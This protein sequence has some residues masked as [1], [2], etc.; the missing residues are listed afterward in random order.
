MKK[1]INE[2]AFHYNDKSNDELTS[3]Y[4]LNFN[5]TFLI[6]EIRQK[7]GKLIN[8]SVELSKNVEKSIRVI[9]DGIMEPVSSNII[10]RVKTFQLSLVSQ[11]YLSVYRE[12]ISFVDGY[13]EKLK[14]IL[15]REAQICK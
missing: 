15:K 8:E 7:M 2:Q 1:T 10:F 14:N 3:K 11:D 5:D 12:H 6:L 9:K 4:T 13:E